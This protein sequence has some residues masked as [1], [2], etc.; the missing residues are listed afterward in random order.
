[1]PQ[2]GRFRRTRWGSPGYVMAEVDEFIA[3]I[4]ATLNGTAAPG[5]AV[6]AGDTRATQFR[7][8][9]RGGYDDSEVDAALDRY[10]EEL[11]RQA[12]RAGAP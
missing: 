1:M 11:T 12:R 6:V 4:E 5:Q 7:F 3:R 2:A 9:R 8:T 10:A